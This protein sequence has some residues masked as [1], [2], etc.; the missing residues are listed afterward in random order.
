MNKNTIVTLIWISVWIMLLILTIVFIMKQKSETTFSSLYYDRFGHEPD[1]FSLEKWTRANKQKPL[2]FGE[3]VE[4]VSRARERC[5]HETIVFLGLLRNNGGKSLDFWRSWIELLGSHFKDYKAIFVENDS[6]DNTREIL[7]KENRRNSKFMVYCPFQDE[8]NGDECN[9][10]IVSSKTKK[11]KETDLYNRL[12]V[13]TMIREQAVQKMLSSFQ[14]EYLVILDWDLHGDLSP[15]GFFH[16]MGIL[17]TKK[18]IDA[19]CVNSF[20]KNPKTKGGWKIYDT[21]PLFPPHQCREI[22]RNKKQLDKRVEKKY[23]SIFKDSL[24]PV[25]IHSAFGGMTIYKSSSL[26]QKNAHYQT[27][28]CA[29]QCEHTSFHQNLHLVLDPWFVFLVYKNAN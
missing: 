24:Y 3:F 15:E 26:K 2:F 29:V 5:E 11:D 1:L 8:W 23:H 12:K 16:A 20:T 14:F 4:Q 19:V 10:G 28:S 7:L 27:G 22:Y 25:P 13:L 18:E 17:Q 6:G 9:L 21:F